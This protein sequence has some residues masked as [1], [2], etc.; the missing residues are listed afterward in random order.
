MHIS[1]KSGTSCL[2]MITPKEVANNKLVTTLA[3]RKQVSSNMV[4]VSQELSVV[5]VIDTLYIQRR[6][7]I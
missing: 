2:A 5:I 4:F 6:T 3:E 7:N 1:Q